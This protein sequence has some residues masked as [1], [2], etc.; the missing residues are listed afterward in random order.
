MKR[1]L[2]L[3]LFNFS[4]IIFNCFAQQYGWIE[5]SGNLPDFYRD[6]T[7]INNGADT[8]IASISGLSFLN[9]DHGWI[10]TNHPFDGDASAVLETTDG[11]LT[12]TVHD[13][14]LAAADIYMVNENIGYLGATNGMVYRTEDGCQTWNYHGHLLSYLYDLEFPPRPAQNGY[15]GGKNGNMAQITPAGVFPF[16]LGLFG[17]VYCIDFPS[18]ER[19]YAILDH[20]MIIYFINNEWH[21]E[22]S[23]PYSSKGW[24]FFLNDTLGWCVGDRFLKTEV[25]IDWYT[26]SV[27]TV[28]EGALTGVFFNDKNNGWA[29]GAVAQI[30]YTNNGGTDWLRLAHNLTD[31]F[32]NGVYFTSPTNGYIIGGN[33]ILLKYTQLT[34]VEY[35]THN[36]AGFKLEQNY[37]NP[38]NPST[39]IRYSIPSNVKGQTSNV[40]LKVYD[41]LGKEVATLVNEEKAPGTYEVDFSPASSILYPATGVYFCQL[42]AGAFVQTKKIVLIK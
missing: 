9:D 10:C 15:A 16:N 27:N 23:Y 13:A 7:I 1:I 8:I 39:T 33:K 25:G 4:F 35:E 21:V 32:L 5:I 11:G 3:S 14:P 30:F 26:T 20:Q 12:W 28:I 42:K 19:G 41:V 37:P 34:S 31:G 22:A 29:V 2:L 6:T 24:L 40:I 18:V 38:F 17:N 36:P